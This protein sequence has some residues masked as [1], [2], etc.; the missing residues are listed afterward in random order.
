MVTE[1]YIRLLKSQGRTDKLQELGIETDV[2]Q[3]TEPDKLSFVTPNSNIEIKNDAI[4]SENNVRQGSLINSITVR[5]SDKD[6]S[7]LNRIKEDTETLSDI[8]RRLISIN[9]ERN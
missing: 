6:I 1:K 9:Y 3:P 4:Q 5:L 8:I 2:I 7:T